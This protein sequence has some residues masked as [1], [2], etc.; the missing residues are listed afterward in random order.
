MRQPGRPGIQAFRV[1]SQTVATTGR[2]F[3]ATAER[4]AGP[5]FPEYEPVTLN[6]RDPADWLGFFAAIQK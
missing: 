4:R 6:G 5:L 2:D 1:A 3:S